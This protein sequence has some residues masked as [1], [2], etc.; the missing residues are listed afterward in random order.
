MEYGGQDNASMPQSD[1]GSLE[2]G[3]DS[4]DDNNDDHEE[5]NDL[6]GKKGKGGDD[7]GTGNTQTIAKLEHIIKTLS[8]YLA[9]DLV[10]LQAMK[11]SPNC[12][13]SYAKFNEWSAWK[14]NNVD[15]KKA[16]INARIDKIKANDTGK[17]D[18]GKD[19]K[20]CKVDFLN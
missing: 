2:S 6:N 20:D 9:G 8:A 18:H 12:K 11:S 19:M 5:D 15:Q 13:N 10:I 4:K 1:R 7:D 14:K 16:L 17:G 3:E